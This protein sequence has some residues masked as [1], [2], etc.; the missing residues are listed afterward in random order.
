MHTDEFEISLSRELDVCKNSIRKIEL[1]LSS[2]KRKYN[3][4]TD[5]FIQKFQN[6]ELAR[7]NDFVMWA[8]HHEALKKWTF[9]QRQYE[10]MFRMMKI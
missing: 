5:T 8:E 9:L 7:C 4:E 1:L 10:E 2:M 3:L 6:G